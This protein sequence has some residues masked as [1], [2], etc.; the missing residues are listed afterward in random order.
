ML[1]ELYHPVWTCDCLFS[2]TDCEWSGEGGEHSYSAFSTL[3]PTVPWMKQCTNRNPIYSFKNCLN[4]LD[5]HGANWI[6]PIIMQEKRQP[7]LHTPEK[8]KKHTKKPWKSSFLALVSKQLQSATDQ[9]QCILRKSFHHW[10]C[11]TL[12]W[13]T[14]HGRKYMSLQ[15]Q[16]H[17]V[18]GRHNSCVWITEETYD[19]SDN[20]YAPRNLW[21]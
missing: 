6:N 20:K 2:F 14:L 16:K 1:T 19:R 3:S 10:M 4:H 15:M 21:Y 17:L 9:M 13:Q 18:G 8:G 12:P 5:I 7:S 11:C